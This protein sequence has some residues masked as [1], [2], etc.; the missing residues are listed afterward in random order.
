MSLSLYS[1]TVPSFQQI[2]TS[3]RGVL[4]K[5]E[6]FAN[7]AGLSHDGLIEAR[8][9]EDM[10]PFSYQIKSMAVHSLGAIEGVRQGRFVPDRTTPPD[11][12]AALRQR[13]DETLAGL[14]ALDPAEI[15]SLVGQPM[16]FEM[17]DYKVDYTAEDFL[18]SFSIPN[19]YFHATTAY[20]ILRSKGVVLGKA[21]YLGR[22]RGKRAQPA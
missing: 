12:F 19:F 20:D 21:D 17:G 6:A 11:S 7:Q 14:A 9:I 3:L 18:F 15:D 5:G 13:I 8:L 16:R 2:L 10:L 4:D 1:V 22:T